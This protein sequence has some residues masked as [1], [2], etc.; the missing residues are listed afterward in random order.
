MPRTSSGHR[1]PC[2]RRMWPSSPNSKAMPSSSMRSAA[3]S[4]SSINCST[5][6]ASTSAAWRRQRRRSTS[7]ATEVA[8][9][10]G[11]AAIDHGRSI[12]VVAPDEPVRIRGASDYLF[13]ALRNIVENAL[14][15][16]PEGTTVSI[17]VANPPAISVIDRGPGVPADQRNAIFRRFWQGD[18]GANKGGAGLGDGHCRPHRRCPWGACPWK[19]HPKG[20][21]CSPC[22]LNHSPCRRLV[23]A[24]RAPTL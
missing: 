22:T 20:A 15:Y 23:C 19:M 5:W 2:S 8:S 18:R 7:V 16:T 21:P 10:L 12:E 24:S 17:V 13:R 11:P 1:S 4:G 6:L 3:L 14:R 9:H